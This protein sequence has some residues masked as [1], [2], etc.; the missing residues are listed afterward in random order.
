MHT[1][2]HTCT[3]S[4][5]HRM[6][7]YS[8]RLKNLPLHV[9]VMPSQK[10]IPRQCLVL[11]PTNLYPESQLKSHFVSNEKSDFV[12]LMLPLRGAFKTPQVFT[13]TRNNI[14]LLVSAGMITAVSANSCVRCQLYMAAGVYSPKIMYIPG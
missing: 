2:I 14:I 7:V 4:L 11:E 13:V 8:T 10:P 9:A 1:H 5:L 3:H 6:T 12:H